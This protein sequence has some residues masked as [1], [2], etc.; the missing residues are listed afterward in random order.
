MNSTRRPAKPIGVRM[1][2]VTT[3]LALCETASPL[4]ARV[5]PEEPGAKPKAVRLEPLTAPDGQPV[6]LNA[7]KGG[8]SVVVFLSTECPISNAYSPTL[9]GI[10]DRFAGR[11]FRMVG[12]CVDHDLTDADVAAHARDFGLKFPVVRDRRGVL[13]AR[14][15]A[16]VTPEAFVI[17]DRGRVRYHGR[18]D[19]QFAARRLRNANPSTSELRD[20]VAAVLAGVEVVHPYVESVGCPIPEP[21]GEG[22][23]PK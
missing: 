22:S 19:D 10:V 17:D 21:S 23:I 3:I 20:A 4:G 1:L 15:G 11:A 2:A 7:P 8:V 9:N 13:A 12:V 16:K 5:S 18:I 14:L 6:D